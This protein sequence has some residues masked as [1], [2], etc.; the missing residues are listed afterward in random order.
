MKTYSAI[1]MILVS[2]GMLNGQGVNWYNS[3]KTSE[4]PFNINLDAAYEK[5][6]KDK[7]GVPVVVAVIDS[8]VDIEHEDL[9]DAI[10]V[11]TDEIPDNG[12]DDD[13]NGYIDDIHGWN[14]IGGKDGQNV[15]ADTY[16]I[17]R[18]Y[19][20]LKRKYD[21]VEP[22]RL[23]KD[24]LA[25]Y[26]MFNEYGKRIEKEIRKAR[27][28]YEEFAAQESLFTD[29]LN[30]LERA[31][32]NKELSTAIADSLMMASDQLSIIGSNILNY[33]NNE[34]GYIPGVFELREDILGPVEEAKEYYGN[35]FKY[36]YNIDFDPRD[37]V[38]DNYADLKERYYGNNK[39][40]GPD[41]Y[42]GTHV[43][44]I[45]AATR[46]NGIGI[47]GIANNVR[48]MTIRAVPDGDERD[49]DIANAIRYAVENGASIINMS[50]GK[51]Q[52]PHKDI[53]DEAVRFAE[54][55]DVLI[56]HAAGNSS[57]SV[58]EEDNFPNDIYAKPKGFLFWK[59]K[60]PTNWISVG[61]SSFKSDERMVASFSNYGKKN[62]DVFA[63]GE[64][65]FS[66]IPNDEY[67]ASQGTSM[68][69]PVVTGLAALI[70][71][72][73][74]ALTAAQVREII[75]ASSVPLPDLVM[76]PGTE[77]LVPFSELSVSGGIVDVA[78]AIRLAGT[79]KG[80]KK[81]VRSEQQDRA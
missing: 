8:G 41:A 43:A 76:K 55:N 48:I 10:W 22:S 9:Q 29:V 64:A 5:L 3:D 54:K 21:D 61:A 62:V 1:L 6:L 20:A 49:K 32:G 25:E 7:K 65:I 60:K 69:A 58:D 52:S 39:V 23:S 74:P 46:D 66:T 73:F 56:V 44:G 51:G 71:S 59:R 17:T 63:P 24:Q 19:S 45:I 31:A 42:H 12:I 35:K 70:R 27:K 15:D 50:F 80:K 28:N 79:T 26:N 38:G 67:E 33:Y 40:E 72:H 57:L 75:I 13:R 37:I 4:T 18:L 36:N 47:N 14:F 68:A 16:E 2:A 81:R 77:D 30:H 34:F 11:N 78:G 53:V